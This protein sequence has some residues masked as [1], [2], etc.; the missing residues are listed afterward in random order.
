MPILLT[1]WCI[2]I[3][4]ISL[5]VAAIY[6]SLMVT[7]ITAR[8]SFIVVLLTNILFNV[9]HT[10][11]WFFKWPPFRWASRFIF[12]QPIVSG[13]KVS[14]ILRKINSEFCDI[15][16]LAMK[17]MKNRSI[18]IYY[19][20]KHADYKFSMGCKYRSLYNFAI[21]QSVGMG[22]ISDTFWALFGT[23]LLGSVL[24]VQFPLGFDWII[25]NTLN[26]PCT[27]KPKHAEAQENAH[28]HTKQ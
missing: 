11:F 10:E 8:I 12:G 17:H 6:S 1:T 22:Y 15:D 18:W 7:L 5:N 4:I 19:I 13:G 21:F 24:V 28:K 27:H 25:F 20:N 2:R 3:S 16:F 26:V 23:L 14:I 9:N